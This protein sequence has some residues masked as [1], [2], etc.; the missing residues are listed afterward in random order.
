MSRW[1][2][3]LI[4]LLATLFVAWLSFGPLGRGAAYVDR[5][6]AD[7]KAVIADIK[8]HNSLPPQ[9]TVEMHR[10]PLSRVAI[11][12]GTNSSFV[13]CGTTSFRGDNGECDL[14]LLESDVPG[15]TQRVEAVRGM[16]GVR[17]EP[18]GRVMP[19]L[20]ELMIMFALAY[21][22]GV[23]LGWLFFR[24]RRKRTGYLS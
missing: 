17:W 4:G 18:T 8:A 9:L 21:G 13:R 11:L 3:L 23:G 1:L 6:E 15:V 19:L 2:K 16:G 14:P 5:L 10:Q 24:P 12:S 7:A 22:I 20:G